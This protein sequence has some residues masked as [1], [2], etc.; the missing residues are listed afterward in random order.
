MEVPNRK[1]ALAA[2]SL[3]LKVTLRQVPNTDVSPPYWESH[4]GT[5]V[6]A[7]QGS[8]VGSDGGLRANWH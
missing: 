6:P 7:Y 5:T 3:G 2:A 8:F 4:A 1:G